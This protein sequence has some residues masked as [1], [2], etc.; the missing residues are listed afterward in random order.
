M[1]PSELLT[2]ALGV[3][4][5]FDPQAEERTKSTQPAI[6]VKA[7][8]LLDVMRAF[9]DRKELG[10]DLLMVHTAVDW[11]KEERFELLYN[12]MAVN[13]QL[14]LWVSTS[15]P[16]AI[17]EVDSVSSLFP[18]AEF[19]EREVYDLFGVRYRGHP[20]LRR[21]LLEDTWVGF[22]LRKDYQD[23]FMLEKPMVEKLAK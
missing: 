10:F 12:L 5:E 8:R 19:Q 16:R 11:I 2:L 20:D 23:D 13:S 4:R 17:P 22:P 15:V 1:Q 6:V 21:I 7:E 14:Q 3:A 9:R 18:I